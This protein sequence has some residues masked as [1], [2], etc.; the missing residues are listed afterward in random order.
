MPLEIAHQCFLK[1]LVDNLEIWHGDKN[2]PHVLSVS[3]WLL[4][5]AQIP[6]QQKL[7][8]MRTMSFQV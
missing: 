2:C 5:T 1:S 6:Q 3:M 8:A 7:F 4:Y